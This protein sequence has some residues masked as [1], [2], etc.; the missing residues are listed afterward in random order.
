MATAI[1]SV[2]GSAMGG[3]DKGGSKPKTNNSR[4]AIGDMSSS[5]G[6]GGRTITKMSDS[7]TISKYNSSGNP[8]LQPQRLSSNDNQ[9]SKMQVALLTRIWS[10]LERIG[11]IL[12]HQEQQ[13][14]SDDLREREERFIKAHPQ[15]TAG[16]LQSKE[17]DGLPS[18][19]T[20]LVGTALVAAVG[21]AVVGFTAL[22]P[23]ID[24][25]LVTVKKITKWWDDYLGSGV[26]PNNRNNPASPN[27]V[28]SLDKNGKVIPG[29]KPGLY[30]EYATNWNAQEQE[31]GK[32]GWGNWWGRKIKEGLGIQAPAPKSV[33]EK[34]PSVGG[35]SSRRAGAGGMMSGEGAGGV[36]P[37]SNPSGGDASKSGTVSPTNMIKSF[38]D[39]K[40]GAYWDNKQYS[41]GW[42]SGTYTRNGKVYNTQSNTTVTRAEADADLER[43]V[44]IL[45]N[46][47]RK[48]IGAVYWDRLSDNV[49]T[50]LLSIAYN[51]GSLPPTLIAAA[52]TG[53]AQHIAEVIR[54]L[55]D[56]MVTK[57]RRQ[58]EAEYAATGRVSK[59]IVD[60]LKRLGI[61][62]QST[63]TPQPQRVTQSPTTNGNKLQTIPGIAKIAYP[64]NG[65]AATLTTTLPPVSSSPPPSNNLKKGGNPVQQIIAIGHELQRK[66]FLVRSHPAFPP[67]GQHDGDGHREN[68]AID[69]NQQGFQANNLEAKNPAARAKF[70]QLAKELARRGLVVLWNHHRYSGNSI[71]PITKGGPHENHL[72]AEVPHGG[73]GNIRGGS[74]TTSPAD[75]SAAASDVTGDASSPTAG[76]ST[77]SSYSDLMM[78]AFK[79]IMP[80]GKL[81]ASQGRTEAEL[82]A[83]NPTLITSLIKPTPKAGPGSIGQQIM[84]E[85]KDVA[86][87]ITNIIGGK[88]GQRQMQSTSSTGGVPSPT[89][90][91]GI[92]QYSIYFHTVPTN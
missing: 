74:I 14:D 56:G 29:E 45:A 54:S 44:N 3:H 1:F 70:D 34:L 72:H 73:I 71:G 24:D 92:L 4:P 8:N 13:Q 62:G 60:N 65:N 68:R 22:K 47:L 31:I 38:E 63:G 12:L 77:E 50:S 28:P 9:T 20:M 58:Q 78:A 84:S 37:Q 52:R 39:F 49:K 89:A 15:S 21:A 67:I 18:L 36:T 17:S 79:A 46:K 59:N 19:M 43:R 11:A 25:L 30:R 16:S 66:G 80:P 61:N 75:A 86:T 35:S 32:E 83:A 23:A 57:G 33:T 81:R 10:S 42:G 55:D 5:L 91:M 40:P 48:S 27:Y 64:T 87:H 76:L 82:A 88:Q 53:N 90:D 2:L 41:V 85:A 51:K 69:V 7:S 6:F 26:D